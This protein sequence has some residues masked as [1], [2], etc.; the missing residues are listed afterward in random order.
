VAE[1]IEEGRN[2]FLFERGDAEDLARVLRL[3]LERPESLSRLRPEPLGS[4]RSAFD[5]F[6]AL[7]RAG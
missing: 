3:C 1:L 4:L 5:R 7:Y 2:G 6:E